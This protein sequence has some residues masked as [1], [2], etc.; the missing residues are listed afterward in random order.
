MNKLLTARNFTMFLS[1]LNHFFHSTS[2][3]EFYR[4]VIYVSALKFHMD[5]FDTVSKSKMFI[6]GNLKMFLFPGII[7]L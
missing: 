3:T 7:S 1:P 2:P 4:T 6:D 5:H